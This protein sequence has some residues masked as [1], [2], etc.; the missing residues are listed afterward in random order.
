MT[1][2]TLSDDALARVCE[3]TTQDPIDGLIQTWC[4]VLGLKS[5]QDHPGM[6]DPS[7]YGMP[8]RQVQ[9]ILDA[10]RTYFQRRDG[11]A[12]SGSE[13]FAMEWVNK[14]PVIVRED[15]P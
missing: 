3:A 5:L 2:V 10:A 6:I 9:R 1:T 15:Q 7:D 11:N 8:S 4:E 13:A 12:S 14:G